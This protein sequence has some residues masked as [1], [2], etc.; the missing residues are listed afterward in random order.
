MTLVILFPPIKR[1]EEKEDGKQKIVIKSHAF[2]LHKF[3]I[4]RWIRIQIIRIHRIKFDGSESQVLIHFISAMFL[5]NVI[6]VNQPGMDQ[7]SIHP[8]TIKK[9]D[10]EINKQN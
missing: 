7:G 10:K 8:Y 6:I 2:L 9:Y 1:E 3:C 5:V 4:F